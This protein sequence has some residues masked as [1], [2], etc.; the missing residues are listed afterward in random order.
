MHKQEFYGE[1][2]VTGLKG[3]GEQAVLP[4]LET[5]GT[6]L[7]IMMT[8]MCWWFLYVGHWLIH[9]DLLAKTIVIFIIRLI[10]IV[11]FLKETNFKSLYYNLHWYTTAVSCCAPIQFPCSCLGGGLSSSTHTS[12][13][14]CRSYNSGSVGMAFLLLKAIMCMH[15]F[16]AM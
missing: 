5:P 13:N 10:S 1:S 11:R 15:P 9:L 14:T 2:P 12:P 7:Q 4:F 3:I 16:L 8:H 6:K